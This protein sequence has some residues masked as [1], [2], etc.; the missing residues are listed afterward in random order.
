MQNEGKKEWTGSN[1]IAQTWKSIRMEPRSSSDVSRNSQ[2]RISS[3]QREFLV[4][5]LPGVTREPRIVPIGVNA[6]VE[7][8]KI[9]YTV[10]SMCISAWRW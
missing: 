1:G 7:C 8:C 4:E 2:Q 10:V 5:D 6:S 9:P 3:N